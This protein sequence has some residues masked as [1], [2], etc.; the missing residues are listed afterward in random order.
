MRDSRM[1]AHAV[2]IDS[3]IPKVLEAEVRARPNFL[4]RR[5]ISTVNAGVTAGNSKDI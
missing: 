2:S 5:L 4:S 1:V 3:A